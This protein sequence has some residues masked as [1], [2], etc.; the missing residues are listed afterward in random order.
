MSL[1][2]LSNYFCGVSNAY[3]GFI[4]NI[5]SLGLIV[6][7]HI[8]VRQ[9]FFFTIIWHR[10]AIINGYVVRH[11]DPKM[12]H[13][14]NMS[15]LGCASWMKGLSPTIAITILMMVNANPY[16][17]MV[18]AVIPRQCSPKWYKFIIIVSSLW[19]LVPQYNRF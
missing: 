9:N 7:G 15:R 18:G 6:G 10:V 11:R 17:C 14:N 1:V 4:L 16:N 13:Y 3:C 19:T 2:E 8:L 12:G 5:I